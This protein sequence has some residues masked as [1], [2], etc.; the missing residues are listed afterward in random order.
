MG[1]A[2]QNDLQKCPSLT[3]FLSISNSNSFMSTGFVVLITIVL[4]LHPSLKFA[5]LFAI[6][7][8]PL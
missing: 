3:K 5:S 4:Q 7:I 6:F 8:E 1:W 2:E